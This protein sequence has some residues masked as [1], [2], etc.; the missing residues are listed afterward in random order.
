VKTTNGSRPTQAAIA[1]ALGLS[2]SR[3]VGLRL[4]G[5]PTD[6]IQ[7]AVRWHRANIR[8]MPNRRPRLRE[9]TQGERELAAVTKLSAV[10]AAALQAGRLDIVRAELQAAM[11]AV[12]EHLRGQV[13]VHP[14][15]L[16]ELCR[17]FLVAMHEEAAGEPAAAMTSSEA[18]AMGRILYC[19]AA[20]EDFPAEWLD[21]PTP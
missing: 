18:D 12:P 1:R 7:E 13:R 5:M 16:L 8:P 4:M 10:A 15:V 14:D 9:Y 21:A 11:R 6:D 2:Q 3:V 19:M 20:A 17:P